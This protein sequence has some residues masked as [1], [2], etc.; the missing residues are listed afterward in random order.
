MRN[1][2]LTLTAFG[3]ATTFALSFGAN[4]AVKNISNQDAQQM[5]AMGSVSVSHVGGS[6][7]AIR[8][9]LA[10]KAEKEGANG[11]LITELH[12]GSNWHATAQLYK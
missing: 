7:M 5:Q 11:Y 4:A 3:L 9:E 10:H 2:I 1:I 12:Q 8:S 6:P